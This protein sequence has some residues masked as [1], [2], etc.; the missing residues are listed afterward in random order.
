VGEQSSYVDTNVTTYTVQGEKVRVSVTF[1]ADS[2]TLP[3]EIVAFADRA[4]L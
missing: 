1:R 4:S 2:V 3:A